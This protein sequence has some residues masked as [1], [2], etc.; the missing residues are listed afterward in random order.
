MAVLGQYVAVS[1]YSMLR[2]DARHGRLAGIVEPGHS[3][4]H[5]R[6]VTTLSAISRRLPASSF[7]RRPPMRPSARAAARRPRPCHSEV[8]LQTVPESSWRSCRGRSHLD[9]D[10]G[11]GTRLRESHPDALV[12]STLGRGVSRVPSSGNAEPL[13]LRLWD[14]RRGRME[15]EALLVGINMGF[16][17]YRQSHIQSLDES[18]LEL[19]D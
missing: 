8:E 12:E 19:A 16:R 11:S 5:F 1:N 6:P 17:V 15:D 13:C 4:P 10:G 14:C 7:L 3:A 18:R 2:H 9:Q